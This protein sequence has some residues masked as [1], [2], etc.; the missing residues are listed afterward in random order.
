MIYQHVSKLFQIKIW[1]VQWFY[2]KF[3]IIFNI[4]VVVLVWKSQTFEKISKN[5]IVWNKRYIYIYIETKYINLLYVILRLGRLF[6]LVFLSSSILKAGTY[7]KVSSSY[8][9][10]NVILLLTHKC[11]WRFIHIR[12]F[13]YTICLCF[14]TTIN[15]KLNCLNM[16]ISSC[17]LICISKHRVSILQDNYKILH[18]VAFC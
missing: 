14:C 4:K 11:A 3:N 10:E 7:R 18:R 1:M 12:I 16:Q 13:I 5:Q 17:V 6:F 2:K 9:F 8:T 15:M